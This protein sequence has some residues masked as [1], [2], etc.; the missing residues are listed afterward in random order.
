[1]ALRAI[2]I[3]FEIPLFFDSPRMIFNFS[4]NKQFATKITL[5]GEVLHTVNEQKILG[6]ILTSDLSWDRNTENLVKAAN[7]SM[8]LLHAASKFTRKLSDLKQIYTMYIRSRVE[9]SVAVWHSGLTNLNK[10][11]IERVQRQSM[12]IIFKKQ[13]SS[14]E[15]ALKVA[16][17]DK[18]ELRREKLCLN[19]ALKAESNQ[20]FK[21]WFKPAVKKTNTRLKIS[22]YEDVA[23]NHARME[24]SPLSYLTKLLNNHYK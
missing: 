10:E 21:H 18:L 22:K 9:T 19:F 12:K 2:Y 6:T 17:M 3:L 15:D 14:Y 13:Y 1:M 23:F 8:R 20:K 24:K 4:T 16:K 11:M 5:N 7:A